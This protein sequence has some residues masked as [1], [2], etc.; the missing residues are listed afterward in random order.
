MGSKSM[1]KQGCNVEIVTA[2]G[3]FVMAAVQKTENST[4]QNAIEVGGVRWEI[5]VEI[6]FC[7]EC[8]CDNFATGDID[9]DVQKNKWCSS[10]KLLHTGE[11]KIH[12]CH[13]STHSDYDK[14]ITAIQ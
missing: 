5:E 13:V 3:V 10:N 14:G 8:F 2:E 9:S 1:I 11:F 4:L 6:K 7:L 12:S